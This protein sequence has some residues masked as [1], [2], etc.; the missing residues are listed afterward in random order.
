MSQ[1]LEMW[2]DS[3]RLS[4]VVENVLGAQSRDNGENYTGSGRTRLKSICMRR[5]KCFKNTK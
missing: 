1:L 4:I 5:E 3:V 2:E